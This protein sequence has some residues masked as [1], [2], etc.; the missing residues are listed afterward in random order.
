MAARGRPRGW[1]P[2]RRQPTGVHDADGPMQPLARGV[3]LG[4]TPE[5]EWDNQTE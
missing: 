4:S 1:H 2:E 5:L 3:G